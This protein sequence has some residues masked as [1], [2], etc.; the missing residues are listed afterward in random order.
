MRDPQTPEQCIVMAD[1][2]QSH[3]L[4]TG[5]HIDRS[6]PLQFEFNGQSYAGYDGDTLASGLLA[7]GVRVVARSFKYHRPR[8]IFTAGPEEPNALVC[9]GSGAR[10]TPNTRATQVWLQHGLT[11][12]SQNHWPS[13]HWDVHAAS[14]RLGPLLA[15]GFYYKTFMRPRRLWPYYE[16][17]IRKMAGMG[18]AP[19]LPDPDHYE[20][21]YHACDDLVI[22]LGPAGIAAALAAS[23]NTQ[24]R[25]IA[26]D[27]D[28]QP[29]GSLLFDHSHINGVP[30]ARWMQQSWSEL[31]SRA[32]VTMLLQTTAFG[33]YD[34]NL[35][36]AVEQCPASDATG[37]RERLHWIRAKRVI[38]ATGA[39]ERPLV[40]PGNDRPG[41]MLAGSARAYLNRYAV[42]PG[43]KVAIVTDNDSAYALAHDLANSG[44]RV[45]AVIDHR[46]HPSHGVGVPLRA[47]HRV[48]DTRGK[49]GLTS[50]RIAPIDGG[51][52]E[53]IECDTLCVS[54]GWTPAVQLHAQAQGSLR[55]S[56][57][58]GAF[59]PTDARQAHVS[60]GAASGAFSTN[61]ALGQGW[62]A[63]GGSGPAPHIDAADRFIARAGESQCELPPHRSQRKAFVDVQNDVTVADIA[64]AAREGYDSVEH[65]KRYTTLGM[66][67]DQGKTSGINGFN[68]LAKLTQ[69]S[70]GSL[71]V[72]TFRA[73]YV[74]VTFN[75][76]AGAHRGKHFA[77]IRR[78]ALHDA[79]VAAGAQFIDAGLWHR[80]RCYP[81]TGESMQEATNREVRAVRS[82]VG[83]V[84]VSTLGKIDIAGRDSLELLERVYCNRWRSLEIGK[85]RYGLMLR[86]DGIV[87]DDGTTSRLGPD[88][89]F[90]TTSTAHA[91]KVMSH[92]EYCAQ[93]LWPELDVH[94]TSVT[95][96]WCAMAVAGP[97]SRAVLEQVLGEDL[98]TASMPHLGVRQLSFQ[99]EQLRLMRL[100]FSGELAFEVYVPADLGPSIWARLLAAGR[101]HGIT[102][103]GT[104]ALTVLRVEKG[105]VAGPEI[106]GRTTAVDLGLGKMCSDQ[107]LYIGRRLLARPALQ[108]P[109]RP[110]LVGLMPLNPQ[111][112][113]RSGAQ[114]VE[115]EGS[116]TVLG[117]TTSAV[118]SATFGHYIALAL[119]NAG[120]TRKGSELLA[121][122][123]LRD[124]QQQVRVVDP[125]FFDPS[126]ERMRV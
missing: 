29:G 108:D 5:G 73:P 33:Y 2:S 92:L 96:Q 118:Y 44:V 71:G 38:L 6:T 104:D 81:L 76:I 70:A 116:S 12:S 43:K 45:M 54:G 86:E 7:N 27:M 123:P 114:L 113:L 1:N 61:E 52:A 39:H 109:A 24:R 100:S 93:V 62:K 107:K 120:A 68:L 69:R 34:D 111:R 28:R 125:V 14:A 80:P 35:I 47:G 64:L 97:K 85:A 103:Y 88:H 115:R 102:P 77:A 95:E 58:I 41:V 46:R 82:S 74:P 59:V 98:S 42:A 11:A 78:S 112:P 87:L 40:F 49:F 66:G 119:V 31:T 90:M 110:T 23:Q 53:T 124:D 48:I 121:L 20:K 60:I 25:I 57:A 72:T 8:G 15:A 126:G 13:L 22:G 89:Y 99:G 106:D 122:D 17:A 4:T 67:T 101:P 9:V 83:M 63:G 75:A 84:D 19:T 55:Y 18:T 26:L 21:Q 56:T 3:R 30:C 10:A 32:N 105:H 94:I 117:H 51:K 91:S 65:L 16:H 36:A 50:I 37:M 79:H